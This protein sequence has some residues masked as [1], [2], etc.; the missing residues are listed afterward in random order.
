ML[1]VCEL[2]VQVIE[3]EAE[4]PSFLSIEGPP[5]VDLSFPVYHEPCKYFFILIFSLFIFHILKITKTIYLFIF[6]F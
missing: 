5:T 3:F 2:G 1:D 4:N 6:F